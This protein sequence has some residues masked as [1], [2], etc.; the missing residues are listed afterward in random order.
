[1]KQY[2]LK[3]DGKSIG[4]FTI[5]QLSKIK[6]QGSDLIWYD[7]LLEW[8]TIEKLDEL[9]HLLPAVPSLNQPSYVPKRPKGN[10]K[11]I[12]IVVGM[13]LTIVIVAFLCKRYMDNR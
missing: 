2:Y 8:T 9:K 7:G 3:K 13:L 11:V 5:E 6:L 12:L 4:Q 10:I 1:M